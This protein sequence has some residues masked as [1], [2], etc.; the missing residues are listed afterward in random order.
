LNVLRVDGSVELL[1]VVRDGDPRRP[2]PDVDMKR[3]SNLGIVVEGSTAQEEDLRCPLRGGIEGRAA[4]RTEV[5]PDAL[6]DS[7]SEMRS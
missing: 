7:K 2:C 1:E 4:A 3:G 5:P 6:E